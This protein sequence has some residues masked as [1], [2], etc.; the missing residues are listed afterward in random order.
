MLEGTTVHSTAH[1]VVRKTGFWSHGGR[2]IPGCF[3]FTRCSYCFWKRFYDI[4][5]KV[6]W[7]NFI[8][9]DLHWGN[10]SVLA[11]YSCD[12]YALGYLGVSSFSTT[13][14][15][16]QGRPNG[17]DI[18]AHQLVVPDKAIEAQPCEHVAIVTA[19]WLLQIHWAL[20]SRFAKILEGKV[21]HYFPLK[22]R[23]PWTWF[24]RCIEIAGPGSYTVQNVRS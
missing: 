2:N 13:N 15:M 24:S 1:S 6:L 5:L 7:Y 4:I 3:K 12:A 16:W 22:I 18:V 9:D 19:L 14:G 17:W 20:T 10:L 23:S 21:W 11:S 8:L